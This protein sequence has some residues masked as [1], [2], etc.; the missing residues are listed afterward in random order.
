MSRQAIKQV[1]FN[2]GGD[3]NGLLRELVDESGQTQY[4]IAKAAGV[5]QSRLSRAYAGKVETTLETLAAV[6]RA[7]GRRVVVRIE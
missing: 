4:V 1:A 3:L 6:A 5:P 7:T 2:T